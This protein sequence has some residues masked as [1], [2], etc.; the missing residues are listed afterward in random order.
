MHRNIFSQPL[1][2][3]SHHAS[4][5]LLKEFHITFLTLGIFQDMPD[6]GGQCLCYQEQKMGIF[7]AVLDVR[8][9]SLYFPLQANHKRWLQHKGMLTHLAFRAIQIRQLIATWRRGCSLC[10]LISK[11]DVKSLLAIWN[12]PSLNSESHNT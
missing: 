2:D 11:P 5:G 12:L 9:T 6:I 10:Q 8:S 4:I 1:E 7:Q 3:R